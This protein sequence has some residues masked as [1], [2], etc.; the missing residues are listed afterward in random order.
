MIFLIYVWRNK[1][2]QEKKKVKRVKIE[3]VR[4]E[5][6]KVVMLVVSQ[7]RFF[8]VRLGICVNKTKIV[9]EHCDFL[10]LPLE[11]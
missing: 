8:V 5:E 10:F 2:K 1:A 9:R 4:R 11:Q 6:S 3:N 7:R